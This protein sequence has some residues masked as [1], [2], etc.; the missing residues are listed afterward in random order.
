MVTNKLKADG[1]KS[2]QVASDILC[3]LPI[4]ST[5][6]SLTSIIFEY[7]IALQPF[8]EICD[9]VGLN[10]S[11]YKSA[12]FLAKASNKYSIIYNDNDSIERIRWTWAHELG[13][14]FLKHDFNN[15]DDY[16]IQET[17]AN[18]FASQLLMPLEL[19]LMLHHYYYLT[20]QIVVKVCK[21][22]IESSRYRVKYFY[23]H[24]HV[25]ADFDL[26]ENLMG[27]YH[28]YITHNVLLI[29]EFDPLLKHH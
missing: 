29:K 5:E 14:Y 20:E 11:I 17:E 4:N 15:I 18:Y 2:F 23:E 1:K 21:T 8:S 13:H 10:S 9:F 25:F 22:T 26:N 3:E 6:T 12:G 16:D 7:D 19:L 28:R 27:I 24:L